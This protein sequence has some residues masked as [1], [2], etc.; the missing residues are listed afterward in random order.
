MENSND[1]EFQNE[2]YDFANSD[3]FLSGLTGAVSSLSPLSLNDNEYKNGD[4]FDMSQNDWFV[5]GDKKAAT[6]KADG[7][8]GSRVDN[9]NF[10]YML[11]TKDEYLDSLAVGA[12]APTPQELKSSSM[13][14]TSSSKV[15]SINGSLSGN[16]PVSQNS[17]SSTQTTPEFTE[18]IK[19]EDLV[20]YDGN[21]E[22]SSRMATAARV[23]G[24][25][26]SKPPKREKS[27]H[28]VI[29]K[30]YRTNINSKILALRDVVPTLR[31]AA[32]SKDVSLSDL[33]GLTPAS[34][35][36]KASVLT[37]ATE[38]IKHLESKNEALRKQNEELQKLIRDATLSSR[39]GMNLQQDNNYP[40][41][42]ASGESAHGF[43]FVPPDNASFFNAAPVQ[44]HYSNSSY[45]T[46]QQ[47]PNIRTQNRSNKFLLGG[48]AALVGTS[49]FANDND[50][51]GLSSLPIFWFI[52]SK[53]S[54]SS[55]TFGQAFLFLKVSFIL[56]SILHLVLPGVLAT[57]TRTS[58]SEK[59]IQ[60]SS[61]G[62][63]TTW[64]LVRLGVLLPK[65]SSSDRKDDI[66]SRLRGLSKISNWQ[67]LKDYVY[68]SS[69]EISFENCMLCLI[70]GSLFKLQ[71]PSISRIANYSLSVKASLLLNLS[72]KGDKKS[73]AKLNKLVS[74]VDGVA[75]FGSQSMMSALNDMCSNGRIG[76]KVQNKEQ[77]LNFIEVMQDADG[78]YDIIYR[79]RMVDLFY[80]LMC[81]YLDLTPKEDSDEKSMEMS[82]LNTDIHRVVSLLDT[83][84]GLLR[85]KFL[86]FSGIVDFQSQALKTKS[87]LEED[88]INSVKTIR[89]GAPHE[90]IH[91]SDED[92]ELSESEDEGDYSEESEDGEEEESCPNERSETDD[93]NL[94]IQANQ[95]LIKDLNLIND[96]DF[97]VITCSLILYYTSVDEKKGLEL[98]RYLTSCFHTEK[99]SLLSF[100][101]LFK[102]LNSLVEPKKDIGSFETKTLDRLVRLCREWTK[103]YA[104]SL[105]EENQIEM[106]SNTLVQ[107]GMILNG[108]EDDDYEDENA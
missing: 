49:L 30:K 23:K 82:Q 19:S 71:Y 66:I 11:P 76:G 102:L 2:L 51:Q 34:K 62:L 25:K 78:Y 97:I 29:E 14:K 22:D 21:S 50:M 72:Y 10:D 65:P 90:Q 35:L 46:H 57:S 106:I 42:R 83:S 4:G 45:E 73:L 58:E 61:L 104:K 91:Q 40:Q 68:L 38:Y 44:Q 1:F 79:W 80:G 96:E 41:N 39:M 13:S 54:N 36:N 15:S 60:S 92:V 89:A 74:D 9:F 18:K 69:C 26:I 99:L 84:D 32:G 47:Q 64:L 16:T 87:S 94:F 63:W 95:K 85:K 55:I 100:T 103:S 107:K 37:K 6:N 28:N 105:L 88:L 52:P 81:S 86:L 56:L 3:G 53:F 108:V 31:I 59:D 98:L 43:G 8:T 24:S 67:L 93:S 70:I 7:E 20:D 5:N 48:M 12:S 75:L 101:A 27:N 33:E 17:E 77:V